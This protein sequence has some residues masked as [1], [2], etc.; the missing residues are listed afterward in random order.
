MYLKY[1]SDKENDRIKHI[2]TVR[3]RQKRRLFQIRNNMEDY[4]EI[5]KFTNKYFP[6]L[7]NHIEE[8]IFSKKKWNHF[9]NNYII[10]NSIY[11]YKNREHI[12]SESMSKLCTYYWRSILW[13]THYYF[14]GCIDWS[15]YYPFYYAPS[16]HDLYF[17]L[18]ENYTEFIETDMIPLS[19]KEQ[20]SIVIPYNSYNIIKDIVD[21]KP[22]R[23]YDL[24]KIALLKFYDWECHPKI[25]LIL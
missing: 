3:K 22:I 9:Y 21:R 11:F 17:H 20:L 19:T 12:I 7:N 6:I 4:D 15:F 8:K 13:T 24:D 10:T 23:Y 18:L 5:T 16:I 25:P 1:L 2:Y 14:K